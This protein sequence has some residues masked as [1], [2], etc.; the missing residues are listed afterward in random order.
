MNSNYTFVGKIS[1]SN[2]KSFIDCLNDIEW[3][4]DKIR[5][6]LFDVHKHT[7]T[8]PIL[9]DLESLSKIEVAKETKYFEIF[10][11]KCLS[12]IKSKLL[13]F[14][15]RGTILRIIFTK[16]KKHKEIL[17]HVDSGEGLE[18]SKRIHIPIITNE[19]VLFY[20]NGEEKNMKIGEMWEINNQRLHSVKNNSNHD[21]VHLIVDYYQ[22]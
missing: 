9:W 4:E 15:G 14:Y 22:D 10:K 18:K 6:T 21:R 8:I 19:N 7:Q 5:Q 13:N 12:D 20:V 16:L 11:Q 17:P 1:I 2:T 3:D